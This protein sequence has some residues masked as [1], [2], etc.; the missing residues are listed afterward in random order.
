MPVIPKQANEFTCASCFPGS[1]PPDRC[2]V[3]WMDDL[4][5]LRLTRCDDTLVSMPYYR[6]RPAPAAWG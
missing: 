3:R 1:T 6:D 5:R 2:Y 4:R